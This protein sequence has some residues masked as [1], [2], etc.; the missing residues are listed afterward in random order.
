MQNNLE[1]LRTRKEQI[2]NE[3]EVINEL[4]IE[5]NNLEENREKLKIQ[6]QNLTE[7]REN[8]LQLKDEFGDNSTAIN[9]KVIEKLSRVINKALK[10]AFP[11]LNLE[12][13]MSP[14]KSKSGSRRTSLDLELLENGNERDLKYLTSKGVTQVI[15][16]LEQVIQITVSGKSKIIFVDEGLTGVSDEN[17]DTVVHLLTILSEKLGF[18]FILNEH[19]SALWELSND[20]VNLI[21]LGNE[22]NQAKVIETKEV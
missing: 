18:Q 16:I 10:T 17:V 15:A 6:T 2:D 14:K 21:R 3:L 7:H 9:K 12:L 4:E 1:K 8:L 13:S 19:N 22:D 11:Y 20:P 5:K